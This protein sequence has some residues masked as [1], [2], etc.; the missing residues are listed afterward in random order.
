MCYQCVQHLL[1]CSFQDA[2][3]L[4]GCVGKLVPPRWVYLCINLKALWYQA[5]L[6]ADI[7]EFSVMFYSGSGFLSFDCL[8]KT[9][10]TFSSDSGP[11]LVWSVSSTSI[12]ALSSVFVWLLSW[13]S[14][15]SRIS[16]GLLGVVMLA[17]QPLAAQRRFR[18]R[19]TIIA[20]WLR[21][22][23]RWMLFWIIWRRWSRAY[24]WCLA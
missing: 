7:Q 5:I 22:R 12:I 6:T 16:S 24:Q 13:V 1:F 3:D 19:G 15:I 17:P 20:E 14:G 9:S 18:E 10:V 23:S 4:V 2:V 11:P 8:L 21:P